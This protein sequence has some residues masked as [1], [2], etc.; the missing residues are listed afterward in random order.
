MSQHP[1][2]AAGD[3]LRLRSGFRW[4]AA[5]RV[6]DIVAV[7]TP[8]RND[9]KS[10]DYLSFARAGEAQIVLVLEQPV[11]V[12]GLFGITKEVSRIGLFFDDTRAFRAEIERRRQENQSQVQ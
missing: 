3:T 2:V 10:R 11:R 7:Q 6:S 12:S 5:L 4:S 8:K 1:I 9:A